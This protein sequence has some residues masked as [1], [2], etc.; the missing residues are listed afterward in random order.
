MASPHRILLNAALPLFLTAG[1]G[2]VTR[3]LCTALLGHQSTVQLAA[4]AL[5][6]AVL[7]P[8]GAAVS[9]GLRG[10]VPFAAAC[11]D[12]PVEA[13]AVLND[14]R[15]L[16][17]GLGTAGAGVMLG[18]PLIARIGG[19]P[20]DVIAEFGALPV[21]FAVHVLL[22]A[23]GGGAGGMLVALGRSR[24]VLR[25]SLPSA[26]VEAVALLLLVPAMGVQGAGVALLLSTAL[27]LTVSNT[28]LLRLLGGSFLRRPRPREIV[29]MARVGVPMSATLV[30]KFTVMGGITYA[31]ARTGAQGA[32]AHAILI[33]LNG[34]L[35]L[36][37]VAVGQA[38]TPEIARV[39]CAR[40]VRRLRRAALTIVSAAVLTALLFVGE[41]A[42]RLLT[43]DP[44]V[45]ALAVALL[46]LFAVYALADTCAI[47]TA[48]ALVGLRS[49]S[50][51]MLA[52]VTGY[53]L[54]AAVM[55][56][57]AATWGMTGLWTAL[58]AT[59]ALILTLQTVIFARRVR[60]DH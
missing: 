44:G 31:A 25:S 3:L 12:R 26:A 58:P 23:A 39:S 9:G 5:V 17:L 14:A 51:H 24:L 10:M 35:G 7:A 50:W 33:S 29:R 52:S 27:A 48:A 18:V 37:S 2:A 53:G 1:A 21:I 28:L 19:A 55:T 47:V 54:L 13:L 30:V 4:F 42:A 49:S 59:C 15:W 56:P 32:A 20:A 22:S 8:V 16:S 6:S 43:S 40:E 34:L 41:N 60:Q 45:L 46:P 38:L 57:V 36:A 11:R